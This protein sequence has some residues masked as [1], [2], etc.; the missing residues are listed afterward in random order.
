M[1]RGKKYVIRMHVVEIVRGLRMWGQCVRRKLA[2][3]N[4]KALQYFRASFCSYLCSAVSPWPDETGM[5]C[6]SFQ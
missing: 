3:E 4:D 5:G 6:D 2:V 1:K